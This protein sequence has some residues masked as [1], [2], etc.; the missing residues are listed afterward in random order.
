MPLMFGSN[1][2]VF[3]DAELVLGGMQKNKKMTWSILGLG[4]GQMS[5]N[6]NQNC[7]I[8]TLCVIYAESG[9]VSLAWFIFL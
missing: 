4:E 7:P 2:K 1:I 5:S 8:K 3:P 9:F 6:S